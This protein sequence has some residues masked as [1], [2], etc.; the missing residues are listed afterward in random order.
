MAA[1]SP[2]NYSA[3]YDLSK[4]CDD[5]FF[6]Y[7]EAIKQQQ[8]RPLAETYCAITQDHQ[9]RFWAWIARLGVF[10][11]Q[12]KSLD[13]LLVEQPPVQQLILILLE[14]IS[15]NLREGPFHLLAKC[16]PPMT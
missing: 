12:S 11:E 1:K 2:P 13:K 10:E 5:L 9:E 4:E 8:T 3:I 6:E 16:Q 14:L 7:S 15:F